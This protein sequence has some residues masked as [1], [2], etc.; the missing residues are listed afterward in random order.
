MYARVAG[1]LAERGHPCVVVGALAL[2]GH[3]LSRSTFDLDLLTTSRAQGE[4]VTALEGL[5]YQ[6]LHASAGYSN[7]QHPDPAWGALDVI[8]VDDGT[9]KQ[10]VDGSTSTLRLGD[11]LAPV[12]RAEH[13]AAMKVTAIRNDPKRLVQD[14]ADIQYLLRQPG[15][16]R[17][18]VREYFEKAGLQEWYERLVE[19]L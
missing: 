16:D 18:A 5:G 4:L 12:P 10:I 3:G 7:H 6:T 2:H 14:L 15:T 8:Y 9:A 1:L 17:A 19:T 11:L 13:L